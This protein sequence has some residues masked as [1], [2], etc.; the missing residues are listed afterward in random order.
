MLFEP[1]MTCVQVG[2]KAIPS[3]L[4]LEAMDAPSEHRMHVRVIADNFRLSLLY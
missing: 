2:T 4:E 1:D 3:V